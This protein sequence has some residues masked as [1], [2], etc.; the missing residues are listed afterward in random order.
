VVKERVFD[1]EV[2]SIG[3]PEVEG[4]K[5]VDREGTFTVIESLPL[6]RDTHDLWTVVPYCFNCLDMRIINREEVEVV[7]SAFFLG[8]FGVSRCMLV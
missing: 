6:I 3:F 2:N 4:G 5:G 7:I 8:Q 1:F